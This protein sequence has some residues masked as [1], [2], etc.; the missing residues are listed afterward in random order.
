[1]KK[2]PGRAYWLRTGR[3]AMEPSADEPCCYA[4]EYARLFSGRSA[5]RDADAY[6]KKGLSKP[7]RTLVDGLLS[8]GVSGRSVLEIGGGAGAIHVELLEA[9][10]AD[11]VNVDLSPEWER[12]ALRLLDERGLTDRVER[13]VGDF[14]GMADDVEAADLVVLHR[15]VCCYP[16][17]QRLL[18]LAVDK[19]RTAVALTF[20]RDA[21]ST[22]LAIGLEN[23]IRWLRRQDFRAYVHPAQPMLSLV[24]G[25]GFDVTVDASTLAW[26][27]VVLHRPGA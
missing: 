12:T 17:W 6:R 5:E 8:Q 9:G 19:A 2:L 4:G 27:T 11:V 18:S 14:V 21:H 13:R 25:A 15:V 24:E 22:R 1:M 26:R 3:A 23:L 7:A 16:D 20:P 10:A